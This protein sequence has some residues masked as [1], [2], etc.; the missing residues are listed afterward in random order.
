MPDPVPE[1]DGPIK[2]GLYI[3][4]RTLQNSDKIRW[5]HKVPVLGRIFGRNKVI[6]NIRE[7]LTN[8]S[9]EDFGIWY[10]HPLTTAS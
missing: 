5:I 3:Y 9:R 6:K 10:D 1:K 2:T 8:L 4:N 7:Q